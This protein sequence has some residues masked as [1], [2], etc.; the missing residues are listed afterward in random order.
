MTSEN[1]ETNELLELKEALQTSKNR[2]FLSQFR[3]DRPDLIVYSPSSG[4]VTIELKNEEEE[5]IDSGKRLAEKNRKLSIAIPELSKLRVHQVVV[6]P[7]CEHR[8]TIGAATMVI[9]STELNTV[10][11]DTTFPANIFDQEIADQV[12]LRLEPV[13]TFQGVARIPQ[14]D[15]GARERTLLRLALDNQQIEIATRKVGD[16]LKID[17][18]PGSGKTLVLIARARWFAEAHPDWNIQFVSYNKTLAGNLW[19]QFSDQE[20]VHVSTFYDFSEGRGHKKPRNDD[21][22]KYFSTVSKNVERDIDALFIDEYQDFHVG[23]LQYCMNTVREGRGGITLAGDARQALYTFEPPDAA[24]KSRRVEHLSL[25][26]PYRSTRQ[27][28][29]LACQIDPEFTTSG[30]SQAPEGLPP[31]LVYAGSWN[32]Q[33]DYIAWEISKMVKSGYRKPSEIAVIT[34]KWS[35]V[36]RLPERLSAHGI[37]SSTMGG[38][39]EFDYPQWG[40]VTLTTVHSAKGYEFDVVFLM[41]VEVLPESDGNAASTIQRRGAYVGPTRARDELFIT[42]TKRNDIIDKLHDGPTDLVNTWTWPDDFEVTR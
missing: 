12:L 9:N 26:L 25:T 37:K 31:N 41:A 11:F 10:D 40:T 29:N 15:E 27:I 3:N 38:R 30:I 42:Y 21:D 17:G 14:E 36:N 24:L 28:L 22:N 1:F 8:T 7:T 19:T 34:T 32:D 20:N 39:G 13:F 5:A 33:A 35:A 18:P 16:V 2:I 23:W 6:D 4:F